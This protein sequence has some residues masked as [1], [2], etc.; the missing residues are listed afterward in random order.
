VASMRR[1][2]QALAGVMALVLLLAAC[3]GSTEDT[4][5][6]PT[7]T[8]VD[9]R[10]DTNTSEAGVSETDTAVVITLTRSAFPESV[11]VPAGKAVTWVNNSSA[12]HEIQ[13][14]THD[15]APADMDPMRLGVDEQVD[16]NLEDGTWSYF[17]TIHSSMTGTLIVGG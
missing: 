11:A 16:V 3:G 7:G 4:T 17:C 1:V 14:E 15:G 2:L 9:E 5:G 8:S 13:I 10:T 12:P 6:D